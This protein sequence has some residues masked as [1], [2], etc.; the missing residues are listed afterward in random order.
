MPSDSALFDRPAM[1]VAFPMTNLRATSLLYSR[2]YESFIVA[3]E[4]DSIRG[5]CVRT[6]GARAE[7]LL[8]P[9]ASGPST[10]PTPEDSKGT[11][12]MKQDPVS[13]PASSPKP[14]PPQELKITAKAGSSR[15]GR[16]ARSR[17]R[18]PRRGAAAS[19]KVATP[20]AKPKDA[21]TTSPVVPD[22]VGSQEEAPS[23]EVR[24]ALWHSVHSVHFP[25]I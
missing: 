11:P 18:S 10:V 5:F 24:T 7:Q 25:L 9:T 12:A 16:R 6:V 14:T 13:G 19:P 8:S 4:D 20:E 17:S 21:N 1:L 3:Y 15:R 22:S 2:T 23:Q